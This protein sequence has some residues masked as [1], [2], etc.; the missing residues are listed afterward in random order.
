MQTTVQNATAVNMPAAMT[1]LAET[2]TALQAAMKAFGSVQSLSLF[3]Y[4]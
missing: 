4:L 1:T 3:N 2:V